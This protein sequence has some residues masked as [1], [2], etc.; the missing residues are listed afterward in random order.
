[1]EMF[2]KDKV[3]SDYSYKMANLAQKKNRSR[4]M[5]SSEL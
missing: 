4:Q 1:M 2:K 3:R 5:I